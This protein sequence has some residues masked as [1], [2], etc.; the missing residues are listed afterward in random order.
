[1][2]L[3]AFDHRDD[4]Y[5]VAQICANGHVITT[6]AD[7]SP[8]LKPRCPKCGAETVVKCPKCGKTIQ[9]EWPP[10]DGG[11]IT[12]YRPG[13]F[14]GRRKMPVPFRGRFAGRTG[15]RRGGVDPRDYG[16]EDPGP[17][18]TSPP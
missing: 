6:A 11:L 16:A 12:P 5:C 8:G 14:R 7:L 4:G 9:G 15:H 10:D 1:M 18:L 17:R 13:T 3:E 2:A